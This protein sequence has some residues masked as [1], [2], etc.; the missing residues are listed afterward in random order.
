MT[1]LPAGDE[2]RTASRTL[3]GSRRPRPMHARTLRGSPRPRPMHART[4]RRRRAS[5]AGLTGLLLLGV[6][7]FTGSW[8]G[9]R[10][11]IAKGELQQAQALVTELKDQVASGQYDGAV[12]VY[13]AV[14][15]HTQTARELTDDPLWDVTELVPI[16]GDNLTAMREIT[17]IVD[18]AMTVAQPLTNLASSL[19]PTALAPQ[20]GA[21]PMEPL[22]VAATE[23]PVAATAFAA[24]SERLGSV[25]TEGTVR[26]LQE[27]KTMLAS[28][29]DPAATALGQ[30]APV[31]SVLPQLLGADGNRTYVVMFMNN[32]ELRSLGGTAL[33]FAEIT[34]DQGKIT[35]TRQVPAGEGN[36]PDRLTSVIPIDGGFEGLY[37][38]AL[39]RFVAN[40][41][42]RPSAET[43]AQIVQAEWEEKFQTP[44]DGVISI[45]AGALSFLLRAV[46]PITLSTGDVVT[47]DN[48]VSLLVNTVYVRYN[49]GDILADNV[50]QGAVYAETLALTFAQLSS[51]GF[52]L[53]TLV[54]SMGT[55]AAENR[56]SVWFADEAE[57]TAIAETSVAAGG[58]PASSEA[59]DVVGVYLNDQVGAKL[60]FYL[61][62]RITSGSAVCTPDGRQ[63]H[64]LTVTLS[65]LLP[66]EAV[67][68]LSPS[69]SGLGYRSL[70]LE[71][72]AQRLL[73]FLYLPPGAT[74][75][76][77]VQ[78][79]VPVETT[80]QQD[81]DHPVQTVWVLLPPGATSEMTVDVLMGTPGTRQLVTDVTPMISG[82]ERVT[83]PLDCATVTLP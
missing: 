65:S 57:R 27:A 66:P 83:A 48:V 13:E 54:N 8:V 59:E 33:S 11:W 26:Q 42:F 28:V 4:P 16:L 70:K 32:A 60:N 7:V 51:G 12:D 31:V 23:V 75:L 45:D 53:M 79:G 18:D 29:I 9:A 52:D 40:A 56:L 41:T 76:S 71:K 67:A 21:L 46:G 6:V 43:A 58:L 34:V 69:I 73:V 1:W 80:N 3:R 5:F 82:V 15:H 63:V 81:A 44:V 14:R 30:A 35:L 36:F 19:D 68:G 49:S 55:A 24:L 22:A 39:G 50:N 37:S 77:T 72:G 61:G 62:S 78:D 38:G 10:A 64:R 20:D 25:S 2:P 47:A 17:W 74:V